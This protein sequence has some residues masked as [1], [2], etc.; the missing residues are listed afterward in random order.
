VVVVVV[1]VGRGGGGSAG[2]WRAHGRD[3]SIVDFF[4]VSIVS[5]LVLERAWTQPIVNVH[6]PRLRSLATKRS[7]SHVLLDQVLTSWCMHMVMVDR[8][9]DVCRSPRAV[10]RYLLRC[11]QRMRP[12]GAL[13]ER[14]TSDLR[15]AWTA[16]RRRERYCGSSIQNAAC[17][18]PAR[19]HRR[20][21]ST[22]PERTNEPVPR[23]EPNVAGTHA[24]PYLP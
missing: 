2:A 11:R 18:P 3:V 6:A 19:V 7:A 14:R 15:Y 13:D 23:I 24:K 17:R 4:V 5:T 10:Q 16:I 22:R 9:G 12:H 8:H 21:P 20:S 1:V